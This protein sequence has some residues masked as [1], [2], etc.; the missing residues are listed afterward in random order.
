MNKKELLAWV[1]Y[2]VFKYIRRAQMAHCSY[3]VICD[4]GQLLACVFGQS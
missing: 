2:Q 3:Y 1:L 4:A